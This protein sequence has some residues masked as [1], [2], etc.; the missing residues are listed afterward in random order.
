MIGV[1]IEGYLVTVPAFIACGPQAAAAAAIDA[2][3]AFET[4]LLVFGDLLTGRASKR[5]DFPVAVRSKD[6]AIDDS[7]R[8]VWISIETIQL[9]LDHR[10][11]AGCF[12]F[13][14][15]DDD[16]LVIAIGQNF[17]I[18]ALNIFWDRFNPRFLV[19][20]C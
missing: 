9:Q 10:V 17:S 8:L 1:D 2:V 18:S 16:E 3:F 5:V 13:T 4:N 20:V 7:D 11:T 15:I 14:G 6:Q 12:F 19:F